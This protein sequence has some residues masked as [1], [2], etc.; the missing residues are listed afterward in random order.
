MSFK[1]KTFEIRDKGTFIPAI[2]IEIFG[3]E[4]TIGYDIEIDLW[5]ARCAGYR[6]PCILL[7]RMQGGQCE[8]D[9]FNWNDRTMH[10]A[11]S[12]IINNW[13]ILHSGSVIDV[14][15]ILGESTECKISERLEI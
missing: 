6:E 12:H 14:E 2:A 15:F 8:Y 7:V 11:H 13:A 5:L 1:T 10:V 3:G 9:Q 4:T